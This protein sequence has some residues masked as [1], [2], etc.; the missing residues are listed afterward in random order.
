MKRVIVF[1]VVLCALAPARGGEP[2][3]IAKTIAPFLDE[4]AFAVVRMDL[5]GAN[6]DAILQKVAGLGLPVEEMQRKLV[7][8]W[9]AEVRKAGAREGYLVWSLADRLGQPFG[10]IP[11]KGEE[12]ART[13]AG[14]I[15]TVLSE[16]ESAEAAGAVVLVGSKNALARLEKIKAGSFP[17]LAKAFAA[18]GESTFQAVVVPPTTVRRA[19]LEL[20]P[21]LP[22]QLGNVPV[23][24]VDKGILWL[25]LGVN[26]A[27]KMSIRY[28][29]KSRDET[30]ARDLAKLVD[31]F[32][33]TL[34]VAMDAKE[35]LPGWI[36]VLPQLSPKAQGDRVVLALDDQ[37]ITK[38][39]VPALEQVRGAAGRAQSANNL[40]QMGLAMHNY[41]DTFKSLPAHASF[42]KDGKPLLSWRVHILPFVEGQEL[43]KEFHLDEPWDSE[44]N[45]QLI[46]RMPPIYRSPLSKAGAGKTTYLVPVGKHALFGG[47]KGLNFPRDVPDG[48]SNTIMVVETNDGDAVIWTK[49]ADY[50]VD[51]EN[52]RT[53]LLRPGAKGFHVGMAD[54]SVRFISSQISLETLRAAFTRD[55]GEV[56][57]ND[58]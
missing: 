24:V 27:P 22:P 48:T 2:E 37:T 29:I 11:T 50:K 33:Q 17:D 20:I 57:G 30:A 51:V 34:M 4:Q 8:H 53:G 5:A 23:S 39:L 15:K 1:L 16:R 43:Y 25:G 56:L 3:K 40:K 49:P 9:H 26:I 14:A 54:G 10:V 21:N 55:G 35:T 28:V 12:E 46:A 7:K 18:A 58:F 36:K 47:K 38:L 19:A 31:T 13:L 41:V 6:T 45:K 32:L 52:P 42:D 44:H